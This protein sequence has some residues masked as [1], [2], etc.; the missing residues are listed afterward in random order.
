M[1]VTFQQVMNFHPDNI[2][3]YEEIHDNI[4]QLMPFV[5]AGL[6]ASVYGTWGSTLQALGG[7]LTDSAALSKLDGL[8]SDGNYLD[9][10]QLLEDKRGAMNFVRDL[11]HHLSP[12][13]LDDNWDKIQGGAIWLLPDLFDCPVLTTNFDQAIER[14][15]RTRGCVGFESLDPFSQNLRT[16]AARLMGQPCVFKL[17]GTVAAG[18]IDCSKLVL[19][20]G[21]YDNHYGPSGDTREAL[22]DFVD[23]R[24]LLFLGCSLREDVTVEVL[25]DAA[26]PGAINYAIVSC[27]LDDRDDR[28]RELADAGIRAIVYQ[29]GEHDSV[30]V[31]LEKLLEDL[32]PET[33]VRIEPKLAALPSSVPTKP[34]AYHE[35]MSEFVG[36]DSEIVQLEEFVTSTSD[37][38]RW[39]AITGPGGSGKSRLALELVE[40]IRGCSG[41]DSRLLKPSDYQDLDATFDSLTGKMLVVA[42]YVQ[43][44][45]RELGRFMQRAFDRSHTQPLRLLLV[46]REEEDTQSIDHLGKS[47]STMSWQEL[48]FEDIHSKDGVRACCWRS[49]YLLLQ[50]L[51]ENELEDIILSFASNLV[52]KRMSSHTLPSADD[53]HMLIGRLK[54]VDVGLHRPL[55]ALFLTGA[56][57]AGEDPSHWDREQVLDYIVERERC[58]LD[59]RMRQVT[60]DART[61][62]R[63]LSACLYLW[64][65]AT[66]IQGIDVRK[67]EG[68]CPEQWNIVGKA[69]DAANALDEEDLLQRL[70]MLKDG[71][72]LPMEPD[73]MGE[74]FVYRWLCGEAKPGQREEFLQKVMDDT[75]VSLPF[76]DRMLADYEHLINNDSNQWDRI[77]PMPHNLIERQPSTGS[78]TVWYV[79]YLF[80]A[81]AYCKNNDGCKR[82]YSCIEFLLSSFTDNQAVAS[83]LASALAN[84][85]AQTDCFGAEKSIAQI[86]SLNKRFNGDYDIAK[87]LARALANAARVQDSAGAEESVA[88]LAELHEAHSDDPAFAKALA[89]GLANCARTQDAAGAAE[90]FNRL[91]VLTVQ[92]SSS[93]EIACARIRCRIVIKVMRWV[94]TIMTKEW[95]VSTLERLAPSASSDN[96]GYHNDSGVADL[97]ACFL[98]ALPPSDEIEEVV[99]FLELLHAQYPD[100]TDIVS[101]LALGL[102]LLI[103]RN[104][105]ERVETST[106]RIE[107]IL[108]EYA[109]DVA[110]GVSLLCQLVQ[111][112]M[113]STTTDSQFETNPE[114]VLEDDLNSRAVDRDYARFLADLAIKWKEEGAKESFSHIV[115]TF[116][117]SLQNQDSHT[118]LIFGLAKVVMDVRT[119]VFESAANP[120]VYDLDPKQ[121]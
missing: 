107:S 28:I 82:L 31:V 79:S 70:G 92:F 20:R 121:R 11:V 66:A 51:A 112:I 27:R 18:M 114:S 23:R 44:H 39:W 29:D 56:W 33:Y 109:K 97:Y 90:C 116:V 26:G 75:E 105:Q 5:G 88:R 6:T 7:K 46:E 89:Y 59:E 24:A 94:D 118:H 48:L 83:I 113:Q 115:F 68:L 93:Q 86:E 55:Y 8:L 50:P 34:Y 3:V 57:M 58:L 52:E 10:A 110:A 111:A 42:D 36:R 22:Q 2:D 9:A 100:A 117:N 81:S 32:H 96:P 43:S 101:D 12:K 38:F 103:L 84:L 1:P 69:A 37:A 35:R 63:L 13:K 108:A 61:N 45:A 71:R 91:D 72:L 98:D 15:Y 65:L 78:N 95:P 67:A 106:I 40:R 16:E 76:F 41:W 54:S 17:H 64:R 53:C 87:T 30:R 73:L 47:P 77:L 80:I 120:S 74:Y 49:D 21:Q 102:A 14:V 4:G 25:K 104:D 19:T 62:R 99:A 85:S 60:S 119:R